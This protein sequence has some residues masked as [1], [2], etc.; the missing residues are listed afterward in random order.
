MGAE[1]FRDYAPADL[2]IQY[3]ARG[4]VRS[5]DEEYAALVAASRRVSAALPPE[6]LVYD[7]ASG[8]TLDFYRARGAAPLFV[9]IHGG[10]WRAGHAADNAFVVPGPHAHGFHVAVL[11]YAK[12]PEVTIDEIVRQVRAAIACLHARRHALAVSDERFVVGGTS[13]GGHLTA[14]LLADDW[15]RDFGVPADI[16]G[17]AL[18][19]SGLHDLTPLRQTRVDDWLRLDEG[20]IRRNSPQARIPKASSAHLVASVG[21]LETAE[22]RRQ[23]ADYAAAWRAAGHETSVIDMPDRNHFDLPL[24]LADPEGPLMRAVLRAAGRD[25]PRA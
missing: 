6:R 20:M 3:D 23:T 4:S 7:E 10:Y 13:A 21:G 1:G 18:D 8:Q 16:V 24:T 19:L 25:R 22:F 17:V 9:W 12:A 5:F 11:D 2:D 15:Q 14:M